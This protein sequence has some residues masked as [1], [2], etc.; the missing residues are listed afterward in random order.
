[1]ELKPLTSLM[2]VECMY[3]HQIY[4]H[5]PCIPEMSD[6]ISTGVCN[7]KACIEKLWSGTGM[8]KRK[9]ATTTLNGQK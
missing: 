5:I 3:C 8:L 4:K 2:A 7:D 1:M 6:R 9:E